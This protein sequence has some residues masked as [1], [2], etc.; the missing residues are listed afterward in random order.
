MIKF[1]REKSHLRVRT[2]FKD[3]KVHRIFALIITVLISFILIETGAAP[4]KYKLTVGIPSVYNINAPRDIENKERTKEKATVASNE[5]TPVYKDDRDA[6]YKV[7]KSVEDFITAI[8]DAKRTFQDR[9]PSL[10]GDKEKIENEQKKIAEGFLSSPPVKTVSLSLEQAKYLLFKADNA[11][12]DTF[13][14]A[15]REIILSAMKNDITDATLPLVSNSSQN[16]LQQK[17]LNQDL[18]NIG[19][20]AIKAF[21]IPNKYIDDEATNKKREEAAASKDNI[22]MILKGERILSNGEIVT[23]D[24]LKVVEELKLLE[25]SNHFDFLFASGIFIIVLILVLILVYYLNKF[26]P[27]IFNNRDYC[28]IICIL[29]LIVLIIARGLPNELV[30]AIPIFIIPMTISVLFDLRVAIITNFIATAGVTLMNQGNISFAFMAL[31]GGSLVS[32][33]VSKQS[34]RGRLSMAG[35]LTGI[36]NAVVIACLG[37]I[38]KDGAIDI[39][40]NSGIALLNGFLS[41]VLTIGLM[42]LWESLF[43]VLTPLKLLEM[44]NPNQPL[45]KRLMIEAPGTYHHSLMVG[46]LAEVATEAIG[47]NALLARVGAYFHDVGK[48]SRPNFFKENQMSENPHDRITPNLS[49][50]I[51]TAHT[52]DGDELAKKHKVPVAIRDIIK[53]HHGT[54]L[55]AFFYH[56]AKKGEKGDQVKPDSF[57]YSGPRPSTNEA[58]VVMLA[59]SVEAAVRSL[60]DKTEGKIE[61]LIR[62]IIKDKLDDGQL[63][64]CELT[65]KDLDKIARSFCQVF[66]GFFHERPQ[67]PELKIKEQKNLNEGESIDDGKGT[68]N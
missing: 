23:S 46:N 9:Q 32:F 31:I 43:N 18:K 19:I 5:V 65:L 1:D 52:E 36:I 11:S 24:K 28:L 64:L 59:D 53:Q 54:T 3:S 4:K 7:F 51:I 62:K 30:L 6:P 57:R 58:A 37:L 22:V 27:M 45:L 44:A 33:L 49:T 21:L 61:G 60:A 34:E 17:D 13:G 42:P 15:I 20:I 66:D 8:G 56:K 16:E 10:N 47:G 29:L 50:L 26:S 14:K 48:L 41:M 38:N 68:N 55:V 67:Y 25:T 2:F 63:D 40:I 12:I 35:L 39:G